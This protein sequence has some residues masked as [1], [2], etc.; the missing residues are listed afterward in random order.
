MNGIDAP[1]DPLFAVE[2]LASHARKVRVGDP[3][4]P[5]P[6]GRLTHTF[7]VHMRKKE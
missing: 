1:A 6:R 7:G 4:F 3:V 2:Q 5:D